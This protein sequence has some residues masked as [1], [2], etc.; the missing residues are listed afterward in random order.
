MRNISSIK[1]SAAYG[2]YWK[3]YD[4]GQLKK[5]AIKKIF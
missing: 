2:Q 1:S 4:I 3:S 5:N